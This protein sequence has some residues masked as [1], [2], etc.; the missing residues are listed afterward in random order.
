MLFPAFYSER[1][2]RVN[3]MSK[4]SCSTWSY[5]T[6]TF[7]QWKL[8]DIVR[9]ISNIGY[10]GIEIVAQPWPLAEMPHN[11]IKSIV[12]L[13][14]SYNLQ[15]VCISPV[16]D[17]LNPQTGS[18]E[19]EIELL[20]KYVDLAVEMGAPI[21]RV[22]GTMRLPE[23]LTREEGIEIE[24]RALKEGARYAEDADIKLALENHGRFDAVPENLIEIVTRVNSDYLGVC[25]HPRPRGH[26]EDTLKIVDALGEKIFHTHLMDWKLPPMEYREIIRLKRI[27]KS[28]ESLVEK[29]GKD[30]VEKA[31]AWKPEVVALGEGE[32][33]LRTHIEKLRDKGYR[34]WYNFEGMGGG[35][36]IPE[37]YAKRAFDYIKKLLMELG[38]G[39]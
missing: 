35:A 19:K 17:F 33:D 25:L 12:D 1:H 11:E 13:L 23:G 20:K 21:L 5:C 39:G 9:S 14:S 16:F 30:L 28:M 6:G 36:G 24:V 31:L 2:L 15:L 18:F 22:F 4:I 34:G 10:R 26:E 38:I 3:R 37:Y 32:V 29:Y 8:E 27:G 7:R